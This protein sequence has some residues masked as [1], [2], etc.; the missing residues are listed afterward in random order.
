MIRKF[1]ADRIYPVSSAPVEEGV[2]IADAEGRILAIERLAD[3]DPA[4]VERLSGVLVPGFVNTHCH[5]ELS[6]MKGVVDTGTG[7][8]PFITAVVTKRNFPPEAIAEAIERAE[9][10]MLDSGIVAVGDISNTTDTFAVKAKGRLRYYT[11][12]EA[13]DFLQDAGAEKAMSDWKP[14]YEAAPEDHGCRKALVPHAPYS[15][16]PTLFRKIAEA[17][18]GQQVTV[19][20][21]NQETPDEDALFLHGKSGFY[22]FY[23]RFG[24]DL[25]DFE[26]TGQTSIHFALKYLDPGQRTLFVHNTLTTADDIRAAQA[27][28]AHVFWAT[29]PNANLYIENRLPH[30]RYFI[31]ND[32]RLTIGT[33]SLTSNWQLSVLEEM[34][35]IARYQSYVPFET[36]LR[37]ATLNGAQALGF[38]ASLGSFEVGKRPGILLLQG[39][40]PEGR[41]D[42]AASVR[43]LL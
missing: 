23:G 17:N 21:H 19:S 36:L 9:Q 15:V 38:E 30:Y 1:A 40:T 3:H 18:A 32:A 4:S 31:E 41:L 11:F 42:A 26:P 7:L 8:I 10:E 13:F 25:S 29:C 5:L 35:T 20:I 28:S 6:H 34:K 12:V 14:V 22:D 24:I 43:R 39:L 37:W 2:L 16:S 27:W 33:D